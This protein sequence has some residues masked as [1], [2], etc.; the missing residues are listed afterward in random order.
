MAD[1]MDAASDIT[2]MAMEDRLRDIRKRGAENERLTREISADESLVRECED[3]GADIPRARLLAV[4]ATRR[5][6]ACQ[7]EAESH[8]R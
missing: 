8:R 6:A 5:C 1:M 3:C 2:E 7:E 4:P